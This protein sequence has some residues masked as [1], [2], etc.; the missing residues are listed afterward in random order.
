MSAQLDPRELE[1]VQKFRNRVTDILPPENLG[2]NSYLVRWIR[3]RDGD[4][5]KAELMLR[6]SATW[7]K[8]NEMDSIISWKPP[9]NYYRFAVPGADAE[10]CPG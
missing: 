3:A 9:I 10:G 6:K 2:N 7:Y 4:L 5:E 1:L 8:R